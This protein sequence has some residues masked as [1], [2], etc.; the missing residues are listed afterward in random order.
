[1]RA[2]SC[3]ATNEA[4]R[5]DGVRRVFGHGENAVAAL[6][7]IDLQIDRGAFVVFLGPSGSGKTTLLNLVGG[8]DIPTQGVVE[9]DGTAVSLLDAGRRT[10][11]RK[12]HIGFVFQFFNL[13]P[14]LTA[15]ENVELIASIAPDETMT[16]TR[17]LAAVGLRDRMDRFP[18][19]L[20]GGEQQRVAIARGLA[21]RSTTLLCDEP[22][23]SLDLDTGRQVLS[24]LHQAN[25]E[26]GRTVLLVTHNSVISAMA[27]RVV[28]MRDGRIVSDARNEQ[29]VAAS[30]LEW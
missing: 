19:Q 9:V 25:R 21:K 10:A 2:T 12:D 16:P 18:A 14:T 6:D 3:S 26:H 8:I 5:F 20:S 17:A 23:G 4:I 1:M 11:F 15:R 13:V 24:L 7:G 22:T 29:P 27:D 28:R 30:E